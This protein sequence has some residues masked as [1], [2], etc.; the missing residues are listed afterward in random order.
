VTS[1]AEKVIFNKMRHCLLAVFI[2]LMAVTCTRTANQPT[3]LELQA[4]QQRELS[5]S[6]PLTF[7]ATVSVF[8]DLG[9]IIDAADL[10]TG[11]ITA[12]SPTRRNTQTLAT[13][14][15]ETAGPKASRVRLNFVTSTQRNLFNWVPG[16]TPNQIG[17]LQYGGDMKNDEQILDPVI[18]QSAFERIESAIFVRQ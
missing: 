17:H 10:E 11:L 6:K 16:A 14:F 2:L 13:A 3:P 9:Y 15:I 8:Q 7:A 5:A 18:Y 1:E 12:S 4:L